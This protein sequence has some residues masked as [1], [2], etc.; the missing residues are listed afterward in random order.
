MQSSNGEKNQ[1]APKEMTNTNR[2]TAVSI[3]AQSREEE[4]AEVEGRWLEIHVS[5]CSDY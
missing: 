4:I 2:K 3:M 1:V 5:N